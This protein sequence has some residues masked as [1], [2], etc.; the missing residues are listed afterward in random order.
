MATATAQCFANFY[1]QTLSSKIFGTYGSSEWCYVPQ[2]CSIWR[3]DHAKPC[4]CQF[5]A[6]VVW[7]N[8]HVIFSLGP[9]L[10]RQSPLFTPPLRRIYI[11]IYLYLPFIYL[12]LYTY[13]HTLTPLVDHPVH[14]LQW[15]SV[16]IHVTQI[17][18]LKISRNVPKSVC[19]SVPHFETFQDSKYEKRTTQLK[20]SRQLK[21]RYDGLASPWS[22]TNN[23]NNLNY[24]SILLLLLILILHTPAIGNI[25]LGYIIPGL[26]NFFISK[27][28]HGLPTFFLT[29]N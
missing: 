24:L 9:D 20:S 11:Y 12:C 23:W 13:I 1:G 15:Q 16:H 27:M 22:K 14:Y 17:S 25:N 8:P 18:V 7:L 2:S 3:P 29:I 26:F 19:L 28:G 4:V 10:F 6:P 5:V 21:S